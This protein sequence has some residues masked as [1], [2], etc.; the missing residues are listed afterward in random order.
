LGRSTEAK[1]MFL[2]GYNCAQSILW[3]FRQ[4]SGLPEETALRIACGLGAGM[5]RKGEVCGAVT[6]GILVLGMRHGRGPNDDPTATEQTYAKTQELVHRFT[7]QHGSCL[8]RQLLNG[9]DLTTQNGQRSFEENDYF[10][11][12]CAS[13]VQ[14]V[15]EILEQIK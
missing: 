10:E 5:G 9:C 13:C 4:E 1:D 12:I 2:K 15:V 14:S 6:G 3:A 7:S 8:C 11:K